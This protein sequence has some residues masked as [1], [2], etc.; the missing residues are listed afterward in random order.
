MAQEL[1]H[2][3]STYW[4]TIFRPLPGLVFRGFECHGADFHL[5]GFGC[6]ANRMSAQAPNSRALTRTF[7]YTRG[8]LKT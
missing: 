2:A 5:L 4:A 7:N 3:G 1:R 6:R 8:N